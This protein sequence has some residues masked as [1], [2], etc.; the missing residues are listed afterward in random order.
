MESLSHGAYPR[1]M[2]AA[3]HNRQSFIHFMQRVIERK[4]HLGKTG[5]A[6]NYRATLHSFTRFIQGKNIAATGITPHIIEEYEAWLNSTRITSNSISFY[7]RNMRAIY[8]QAVEERLTADRNPF[9]K[10]YTRIEKTAKRAISLSDIKR[11]KDLDLS[12]LPRLELARD[13]F[14]FLFYCRGMSLIDAAYL[15]PADIYGTE[16]RYRR[17]KTGQNIRIGLNEYIIGLLAKWKT[18]F[19]ENAYL[20]PILYSPYVIV[21]GRT[22]SERTL[23]ESALRRINKALKHIACMASVPTTLTT[24]VTRHSWASIAKSKG[25]PTATISDALGHDSELTTKIYLATLSSEAIDRANSI[26]LSSL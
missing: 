4:R 19:P 22:K 9:K 18:R 7:M 5:T 17:H 26:I 16:L 23:Y 6:R 8:N 13:T 24:Y 25:I 21:S 20:M 14:M 12:G 3:H 10:A 11:I 1:I 15:T 2:S